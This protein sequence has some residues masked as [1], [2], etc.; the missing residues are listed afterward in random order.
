MCVCISN[1]CICILSACR[2]LGGRE[3][4]PALLIAA[5]FKVATPKPLQIS[6]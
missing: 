6:I 4:A 2:G 3:A 1:V 5:S